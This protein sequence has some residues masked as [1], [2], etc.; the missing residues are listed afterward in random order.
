MSIPAPIL[1]D[2][3]LLRQLLWVKAKD[4]ESLARWVRMY[5]HLDLPDSIV[6]PDSTSSP[7][8]LLWEVYDKMLK[9]DEEFGRCLYYSARDA[10]K[11]LTSSVIELLA[12]LHGNRDCAH[13]AAILSQSQVCQRYL[14]LYSQNPYIA[15][16]VTK[17]SERRLEF[18]RY[19]SASGHVLSPVEWNALPTMDD[20]NRYKETTNFIQVIVATMEGANAVHASLVLQD[21]LDLADPKAIEEAKMIP[22]PTRD[23]KIPITLLTSSRK[24][25]FGMVQQELDRAQET[26][27]H[28]RHWNI[29][30]VTRQCPTTR[31]LPDVPKVTIWYNKKDYKTF[32]DKGFKELPLERQREFTK[33]EGFA[34]CIKN[35]KLFAVCQGRLAQQKCQSALLKPIVHVQFLF[36]SV[37]PEVAAAQLMCKKPSGAGL[38]YPSYDPFSHMMTAAQMAE[39]LTG[40]PQPPTFGKRDLL[41]LMRT[42]GVAWFG[43]I[44]HGFAHNFACT[45]GAK[46]G[47]RAFIID[48]VSAPELELPEK[49]EVLKAQMTRL[50]FGMRDVALYADPEDPGA[51]KTLGRHFAIK[52]WEKGPGS[53]KT[54][55]EAVR[56]KMN[57]PFLNEPDFYILKDDEGCTLLSKKLQ[58]HHWKLDAQGNPTDIPDD[59]G[60][61]EC[62]S[63]RYGVMNVFSGASQV[64]SPTAQAPQTVGVLDQTTRYTEKTWM[65]QKIQEL[66]GGSSEVA[67]PI[68]KG[69]F[70][71]DI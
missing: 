42:I 3:A 9:G 71:A 13:L 54:G 51:N 31:H 2:E 43:G 45:V 53:V 33:G 29:V 27:L 68:K 57:P 65:T 32:D 44:D 6:D 10:F 24:F 36:A 67:G 49:I 41:N 20:R 66:A 17:S 37:V 46:W 23:G 19:I 47:K 58:V 18:T 55:I 1:S 22:S 56:M 59:E 63:L 30:D 15:P 11:T 35:C 25:A 16:Y 50:G 14:R 40:D 61:D 39:K 38:I 8:D 28:V 70:F 26:G 64:L 7:M 12:V 52:K 34:G 5:L 69:S 60:K 21:E 62:D 4:K 48:C